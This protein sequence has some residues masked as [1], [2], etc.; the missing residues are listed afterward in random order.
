MPHRL[1]LQ[2]AWNPSRTHK[3]L[4]KNFPICQ[5]VYSK[6]NIA[7][8]TTETRL[9]LG[10]LSYGGFFISKQVARE[11]TFNG[12]F[13][14]QMLQQ[15][16]EY[17]SNDSWMRCTCGIKELRDPFACDADQRF[18]TTVKC[19]TWRASFWASFSTVRSK[20]PAKCPGGRGAMGGVGIDWHI[21]YSKSYADTVGKDQFFYLDTSSGTTG[22]SSSTII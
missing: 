6:L 1:A 3:R 20:T 8:D 13:Q 12:L 22:A 18:D 21:N 11:P 2:N 5:T 9:S 19:P 15:S 10:K 14:R 16:S 7:L 17:R 4:F